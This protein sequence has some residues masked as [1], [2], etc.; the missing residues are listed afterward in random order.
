[1]PAFPPAVG[2]VELR[3][4]P[5]PG[6]SKSRR[7]R[8]HASHCSRMLQ[9]KSGWPKWVLS[10]SPVPP[11]VRYMFLRRISS[12]RTAARGPA[13]ARAPRARSR[14]PGQVRLHGAEGAEGGVARLVGAIDRAA[15]LEGRDLIAAVGLQ[16]AAV[17]HGE[18]AVVG[19]AGVRPVVQLDAV[20]ACRRRSRRC[21]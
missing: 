1:M 6:S 17:H 21:R 4:P 12:G 20:D 3:R 7:R 19:V 15:G 8:R 11:A 18:R 10:A 9:K 14:P 16:Q 13:R 2:P 5:R